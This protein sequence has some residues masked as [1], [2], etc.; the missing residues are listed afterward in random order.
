MHKEK[1]GTIHLITLPMMRN[2][3]KIVLMFAPHPQY[4]TKTSPLKA[5]NISRMVAIKSAVQ[6]NLEIM[7]EKAGG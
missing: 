2:D 7:M 1:T 6:R 3:Q 4:T 5:N